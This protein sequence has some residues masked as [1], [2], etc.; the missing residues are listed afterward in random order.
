LLR[1]RNSGRR[2]RAIVAGAAGLALCAGV[3]TAHPAANPPSPR[4]EIAF[5]EAHADSFG[6][7]RI[8][9]DGTARRSLGLPRPTV[10]QRP[11]FS[12]DGRRVA[13]VCGNFAL[14]VASSDGRRRARLTTTSPWVY[15]SAPTWA[16][17]GRKLAFSSNRGG[18]Y[19]IFV[20][21]ADGSGLTALTRGKGAD[22][23]PAWSPDGARIAYDSKVGRSFR[24]YIVST[25]SRLRRPIGPRSGNA[26]NPAWS[27]DGRWLAFTHKVA[28]G[29][30]IEVVRNDG[31]VRRILTRGPWRDDHAT[32]SPDGRW[33]AFDSNRGG[34]LHIWRVAAGGGRPSGL[35][36]GVSARELFPVWRPRL[37]PAASAAW[38]RTAAPKSATGDARIVATFTRR[39]LL[40]GTDF[41]GIK[42]NAVA[43][44]QSIKRDAKAADAELHPLAV[45]TARGARFK[46]AALRAVGT[47]TMT[48]Q[49]LTLG[50]QA[51][52][53]Q[54][55]K[56]GTQH[57]QRAFRLSQQFAAQV[58]QAERLAGLLI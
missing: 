24:L 22:E 56:L 4:G 45:S 20:V 12:P 57:L 3:P 25:T 32:W 42:S 43:A 9:A 16:P 50:I 29:S 36:T 51:Y 19:R 13:Y 5:A 7:S 15:D 55:Q 47:A 40:I 14:C 46:K 52:T 48:G 33:V 23:N 10:L 27:P 39:L 28:S 41:S 8:R 1:R 44:A 49:E 58:E 34:G 31:K 21:R 6:A 53:Q 30:R 2:R 54:D 17:D 35:T 18:D 37:R 38:P 26:T 11:A